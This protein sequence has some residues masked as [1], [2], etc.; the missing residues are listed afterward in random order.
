MARP[1]IGK[2]ADTEHLRLERRAGG[3]QQI[4]ERP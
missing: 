1:L 4:G 3:V 2:L